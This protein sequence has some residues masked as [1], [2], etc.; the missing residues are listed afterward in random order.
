MAEAMLAVINNR[1]LR[2]R[3]IKQGCQ[4]VERNSWN[5][6]KQEYLNLVDSLSTERFEGLTEG[7]ESPQNQSSVPPYARRV[8]LTTTDGQLH[9]GQR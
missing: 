3:L 5:H 9:F 6:K 2:Q 1:E 4:Y 7:K 8:S